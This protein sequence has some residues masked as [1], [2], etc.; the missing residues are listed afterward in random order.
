MILSVSSQRVMSKDSHT[1]MR[2]ATEVPPRDEWG[3]APLGTPI[4]LPGWPDEC[5]N[6]VRSFGQDAQSSLLVAAAAMLDG[7][8]IR[9]ECVLLPAGR[10]AY[11][12]GEGRWQRP[13]D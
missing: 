9:R 2:Q 13:D 11:S 5:S 12:L 7:R 10:F 8:A 4:A 3:L 6:I 1:S